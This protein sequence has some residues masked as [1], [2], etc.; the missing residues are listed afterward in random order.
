MHSDLLRVIR[1]DVCVFFLPALPLLALRVPSGA[2]RV[3]T[4]W[5]LSPLSPYPFSSSSTNISFSLRSSAWTSDAKVTTVR[6]T[7]VHRW[8][9][10]L[11]WWFAAVFLLLPAH[12]ILRVPPRPK[13][14][15][16]CLVLRDEKGK[17]MLSN[18]NLQS[19]S[20]MFHVNPW[21]A[22]NGSP[23]VCSSFVWISASSFRNDL[24]L[25]LG[26]VQNN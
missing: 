26:T 10:L 18:H 2:F 4:L 23:E 13:P 25:V 11:S 6:E 16:Y 15:N 3:L 24:A 20:T 22:G 21:K 12:R 7:S 5:P 19:H 14:L 9:S 17:P 8:L 1:F